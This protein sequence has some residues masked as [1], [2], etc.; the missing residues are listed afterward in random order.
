MDT[1]PRVSSRIVEVMEDEDGEVGWA[2]GHINPALMTLSLVVERMQ[3]VGAEEAMSMLI[4]GESRYSDD[5]RW[6]HGDQ[7]EKAN[8][9]IASVRHVWLVQDPDNEEMMHDAKEGD[10]GAEPF[11]RV[12]IP[13]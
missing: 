6:T 8:T 10:P 12:D 4:G 2:P 3:N 1:I 13:W 5:H 9:I 7:E 11:T